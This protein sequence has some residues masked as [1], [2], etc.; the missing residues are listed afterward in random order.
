MCCFAV[1]QFLTLSKSLISLANKTEDEEIDADKANIEW[2]EDASAKAKIIRIN[3]Q[4]MI[5]YL[6]AVSNSFITGWLS[7]ASILWS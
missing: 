5:G 1:S 2:P 4:T 7:I 6:E 3:T